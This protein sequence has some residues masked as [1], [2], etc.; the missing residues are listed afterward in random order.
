MLDFVIPISRD[1]LLSCHSDR[2]VARNIVGQD[3]LIQKF[4]GCSNALRNNGYKFILDNFD[5][6]VSLNIHFQ[7]LSWENSM[8]GWSIIKRGMKAMVDEL[9]EILHPNR[10]LEE[11]VRKP[12]AN[13]TKMLVYLLTQTVA[14]FEE[15][16]KR[17]GDGRVKKKGSQNSFPEQLEWQ[18]NLEEAVM[19]TH[20]LLHLPLIW[21]WD[22][23]VPSTEES[24][25]HLISNMAF[26]VLEN[27]ASVT[28]RMSHVKETL[29]HIL[30][31]MVIRYNYK[32]SIVLRMVDVLNRVEHI[33]PSL[34]LGVKILHDDYNCHSIV[35][36]IM[37]EIIESY[38]SEVM[39]QASRNHGVFFA[40][41]AELVPKSLKE[42]LPMILPLLENEQVPLRNGILSAMCAVVLNCLSHDDMTVVDRRQRDELLDYMLDYIYDPNAFVRAKVISLWRRLLEE[43]AVPQT[44]RCNVLEATS[45]RIVDTASSVRKAA[46]QLVT[47][48]LELNPASAKLGTE[49]LQEQL[50]KERNELMAMCDKYREGNPREM[51]WLEMQAN[52]E[53]VL[54]EHFEKEE[55]DDPLD[56]IGGEQG[57]D[58]NGNDDN[59]DEKEE[60]DEN[61]DDLLS[62]VHGAMCEAL[63]KKKFIKAYKCVTRIEHLAPEC[64]VKKKESG[65]KGK[66]NFY[67]LLLGSFYSYEKLSVQALA[68]DIQDTP[69]EKE[70]LQNLT[71]KQHFVAYLEDSLNFVN[72]MENALMLLQKLLSWSISH[73][74]SGINEGIADA[75]RLVEVAHVG[76]V[77]RAK[78]CMTTV[79]QLM[80]HQPEAPVIS[81]I[82]ATAKTVYFQNTRSDGMSRAERIVASLMKLLAELTMG[83]A[84]A[85]EELMKEWVKNG[86]I[87]GSCVQAMWEIFLHPER[88]SEPKDVLSRR[89]LALALLRMVAPVLPERVRALVPE[90]ATH[91]FSASDVRTL[92]LEIASEACAVLSS[93]CPIIQHNHTAP[94]SSIRLPLDHILF[95]ELG[96]M[97][98]SAIWI[99]ESDYFVP[100]AINAVNLVYVFCLSPEPFVEDVLKSIL[101]SLQEKKQNAL[102]CISQGMDNT[103]D[104]CPSQMPVIPCFALGR[105]LAV[106]GH[107]AMMQMVFMD[108]AVYSKIRSVE[109]TDKIQKNQKRTQAKKRA[110][111]STASKSMGNV[112]VIEA[113]NPSSDSTSASTNGVEEGEE[114][115]QAEDVVSE[116]IRQ[117]CENE[118]FRSDRLLGQLLP[119]VVNV[120]S[121]PKKY[122]EPNVQ[123]TALLALSKMM[124]VSST[125]CADNIQLF[126]TVMSNS[127]DPDTRAMAII[128]IADITLRFPNIVEP[129][130]KHIYKRLQD[131]SEEVRLT[132]ILILSRLVMCDMI[133]VR[134]Q[135]S[136]LALCICDKNSTIANA[137][138]SFFNELS[139][140]HNVLYNVLPDIISGLCSSELPEER[141]NEIT[142]FVFGLIK[143][144]KQIEVLVEKLC[145]RFQLISTDRQACDLA[146]CL[147]LLH[148]NQRALGRL[149]DQ[150]QLYAD[151]LHIDKV[152]NY[153]QNIVQSHTKSTTKP[154]IKSAAEELNAAIEQVLKV[155]TEDPDQEVP[156]PPSS[157]KARAT[158]RNPR[159]SSRGRAT[160]S[161]TAKSGRRRVRRKVVWSSSDEELPEIPESP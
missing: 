7:R 113:E 121:K 140:K 87:T 52:V 135:I 104:E 84:Q 83:E 16:I 117:F 111:R 129:W 76:G 64:I 51:F 14:G 70:E 88:A 27:P 96:N 114:G 65:I 62:S 57:G 139:K 19:L 60:E 47:V 18:D 33:A 133:K 36:E 41:L 128:A 147:T 17:I 108:T 106:I 11:A 73:V 136:D 82:A 8:K 156:L 12:A 119:L 13:S 130:S 123:R 4:S 5:T 116:S 23:P 26:A 152:Y 55:S 58:E 145:Q 126:V 124:M 142:K 35:R 120:V 39:P 97:L 93:T 21:L 71:A 103:E 50:E 89:L 66:V 22:P 56:S 74:G 61:P 28:S 107:V 160:P 161:S 48:F 98:K 143:R 3:E 86:D 134:G 131:C 112:S 158:P 101:C 81:A 155:R 153:F 109:E 72:Q 59:E 45:G 25:Y 91:I 110:K 75:V 137:A 115:T 95:K 77:P 92:N 146:F 67:L 1:D 34:A 141:F 31:I 78:N 150:L 37:K 138:K 100:L 20:E 54:R 149:T 43:G 105:F 79:L 132:T 159:A 148:Y 32:I 15:R 9:K 38:S 94:V 10:E 68:K 63:E 144:E 2:Y 44:L 80:L 29:L 49:I 6:L 85:V 69:I 46:I 42:H 125:V 53:T 157:T 30:G 151:K 118:M 102:N 127:T 24:F 122:A 90:I 154:E 99:K 40:E